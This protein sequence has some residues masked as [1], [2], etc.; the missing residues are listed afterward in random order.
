[1]YLSTALPYAALVAFAALGANL[2]GTGLLILIN[3]RSRSVRWHAAFSFWIM[4]WLALQGWFT[5]GMTGDGLM[6]VYGWVIH[7]M[8]AF[9]V[10]ATLVETF[11]VRDRTALVV[12]AFAAITADVLNPVVSGWAGMAWQALMWGTGAV[13]HFRD[14]AA[15]RAPGE[16]G[17]TGE[18][19]LKL[20]LLVV[21]PIAVV[22]V[23][24]LSGAFLL[25]VM[26]LL[27]IVIQF[28]IFIGV[29]HHRFYDIEVRAAR[30]GE[31]AA[32]A[33]EQERL[34]LLGE[35]SATLAHEIRNPLTG[36]RSLTQ[37]L[38]APAVDDA[39][40]KRY[41]TV[42]L[43]EVDRLERIVD[44]LLAVGRRTVVRGGGA[45]TTPLEPLFDD[46][47]LL[48]EARAR[49]AR[50]TV[51]RDPTTARAAAPRDALAQALL[52]LLI[53]AVTHTPE[54]GQVRLAARMDGSQR[55]AI[56]VTDTGPGV[57][58]EARDQ[59]FETFHTRGL[60]AGLGLAVV[61]RLARELGWHVA[62]SDADGGGACFQITLPAAGTVAG[63]VTGTVADTAADTAA[64]TIAAAARP[65]AARAD[66][67]TDTDTDVVRA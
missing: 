36:M 9:F 21:V 22:G 16:P 29:V 8:P 62:V 5:L 63:T 38:T 66:A 19:A 48:V 50:I 41:A 10:A 24:L 51:E 26:P 4:A 53:N 46:L 59:I 18:R 55:V 31:L 47:M 25:Y 17:R 34:A 45:G 12:V 6:R 61:R 49:R 28:L 60:G 30:T 42:I 27:T 67:D 40:R 52:N 7:L 20:A 32:Q 2:L 44:N 37:R 43:G 13:L 3:P 39:R 65:A 54:G 14:R 57:P 64:D 15:R 58:P 1:M 35:V 11:D 23:I 33:V 56:R